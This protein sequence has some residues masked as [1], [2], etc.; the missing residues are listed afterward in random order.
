MGF[1]YEDPDHDYF[2]LPCQ[3]M[4]PDSACYG[5]DAKSAVCKAGR[6][7]DKE[8]DAV[9]LGQFSAEV[10]KPKLIDGGQTLKM[11]FPNGSPCKNG[12]NYR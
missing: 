4:G 7:D 6:G 1:A 8:K 9:S 5:M 10:S 2:V 11:T 12:R 3:P